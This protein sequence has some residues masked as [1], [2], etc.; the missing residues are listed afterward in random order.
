[1]S[2]EERVGYEVGRNLFT[3]SADDV[4]KYMTKYPIITS[5]AGATA[6]GDTLVFPVELNH[7]NV[8]DLTSALARDLANTGMT[9]DPKEIQATTLTGTIAFKKGNPRFMEANLTMAQS[10]TVAGTVHTVRDEGVFNLGF[11]SPDATR[12][13]DM[14]W[15]KVD[16]NTSTLNAEATEGGQSLGT[17]TATIKTANK[18]ITSIDA[19]LASQGM[20]ITLTHTQDDKGMSGSLT[21]PVVGSMTWNG[22]LDNEVLT[23]LNIDGNS[24]MLGSLTA[25]LVKD[26]ADMVKGPVKVVAQGTEVFSAMVGLQVVGSEKFGFTL[27]EMKTADPAMIPA[28]THVEIFATG[29]KA[30]DT[31]KKIQFP[32]SATPIKE[33]TDKLDAAMPQGSS[34]Y[35]NEDYSN[36]DMQDYSGY[37][38]SG[39]YPTFEFPADSMT[40]Q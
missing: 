6:S 18:K 39:A 14:Q 3:L 32:T 11:K 25:H 37:E 22:T 12:A 4:E 1:M 16:A 31:S 38:E 2:P 35:N 9:F 29:D 5:T 27:D 20:E 8:T 21:V 26:G 7:K 10:G 17:L 19:K 24:A 23:S 36:M 28:G 13:V 30:K 40:D 15:K 34:S 33:L